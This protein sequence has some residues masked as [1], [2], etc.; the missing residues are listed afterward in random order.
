MDRTMKLNA[1]NVE[2]IFLNSMFNDNE[3]VDGN[4]PENTV[5]VE[6]I[7]MNIGFDPNKIELYRTDVKTMLSEL[8]EPFFK[9]TGGG[10]SFLNGIETKDG[11]QWA[12]HR[13]LEQ[14]V[15]LGI[16]LGYVNFLMPRD[17][18]CVFPGGM[19]YFQV[20]LK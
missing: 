14:L 17:M 16:G 15:I 1:K 6:G 3:I 5:K 2:T 13:N 10:W 11:N 18:W 19:P 12:E 20:D 9:E 8:P 7:T 4:I